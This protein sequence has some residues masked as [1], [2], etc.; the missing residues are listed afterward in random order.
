[1]WYTRM[2][3]NSIDAASSVAFDQSGRLAVAGFYQS[4]QLL[5]YNPDRQVASMLSKNGSD[6]AFLCVF[7]S[8]GSYLWSTRIDGN[9]EDRAFSGAFD[10]RGKVAIVG[11]YGSA[12]L[13][14]YHS[15]GQVAATLPNSGL[16]SAFVSV[17]D[18][19]VGI[20]ATTQKPPNAQLTFGVGQDGY[21]ITASVDSP[22]SSPANISSFP[23]WIVVVVVVCSLVGMVVIGVIVQ[24]RHKRS[25][26]IKQPPVQTIPTTSEITSI[27]SGSTTWQ[28]TIH[29]LSIPAFLEFKFG[30][31]F[32]QE[33]FIAKGGGGSIYTCQSLDLELTD[34]GNYQPLVVKNLGISIGQLGEKLETAF[35]QEISIMWKFRDSDMFCKVAGFSCDPACMIMRHY[36]MG[37]LHHFIYSQDTKFPYTKLLIC[38]LMLQYCMGIAIMHNSDIVHCDI[39]PANCLLEEHNGKLRLIIADFGIS[40]IVSTTALQVEAFVTSN[41]KGASVVYAAPEVMQR[42]RGQIVSNDPIV[43]KAGDL[44]ALAVTMLELTQRK[45]AW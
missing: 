15:N 30:Q 28:A 34:L 8:D 32:I 16:D 43:W 45:S 13:L 39:K 2:D 4:S 14:T 25:K 44:F 40:R 36:Q 12:H 17:F 42:F 38:E 41:L 20:T 1:L 24:A 35:W 27:T 3:G 11:H 33:K 29:E 22:N 19:D 5:I 31:S 6:G 21:S 37:D 18:V 26:V 10:Q 9:G 23:A 7:A